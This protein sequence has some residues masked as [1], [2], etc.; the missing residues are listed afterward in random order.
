MTAPH[1]PFQTMFTG[2]PEE[3]LTMAA[4]EVEGFARSVLDDIR[5]NSFMGIAP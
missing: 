3:H 1:S 4:A 2:V 5:T